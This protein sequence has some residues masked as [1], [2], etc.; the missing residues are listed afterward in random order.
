MNLRQIIKARKF[1][2]S[3]KFV[4]P[5]YILTKDGIFDVKKNLLITITSKKQLDSFMKNEY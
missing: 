4:K 2:E 1:L 5:R 3:G